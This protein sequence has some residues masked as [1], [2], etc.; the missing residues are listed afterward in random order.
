M[1]KPIFYINVRETF[2]DNFRRFKDWLADVCQGHARLAC[3]CQD[4]LGNPSHEEAA[5]LIQHYETAENWRRWNKRHAL[6]YRPHRGTL[7]QLVEPGEAIEQWRNYYEN[8]DK[9][10]LVPQH[11]PEGTPTSPSQAGERT[12]PSR[13]PRQRRRLNSPAP[14]LTPNVVRPPLVADGEPHGSP[15]AGGD[16]DDGG[17]G[18]DD[19]DGGSS[20][21]AASS[22][23]QICSSVSKA[24]N[25]VPL[26]TLPAL[27]EMLHTF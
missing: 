26:R 9:F 16:A 22:R 2:D 19:D 1:R 21:G 8:S 12:S 25:T 3:V 14:A 27:A 17:W 23:S 15:P 11:S 10:Q 4:C 6:R 18:G 5:I 7:A 13:R 24:I 20:T